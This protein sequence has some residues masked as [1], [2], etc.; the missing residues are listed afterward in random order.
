MVIAKHLGHKLKFYLFDNQL[1]KRHFENIWYQ[2]LISNIY[3]YFTKE[4]ARFL[5]WALVRKNQE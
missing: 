2:I 4:L 1:F 5:Q 3:L